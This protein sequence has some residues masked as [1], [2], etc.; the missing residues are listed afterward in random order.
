MKILTAA[1]MKAA[2]RLS[3]ERFGVPSLSLMENAGAAVARFILRELP[4]R[5]RITVFCGMGNNGGDGYVAARHL[6]AAGCQVSVALLG[7]PGQVKGDAK[8]MLD[9]L[10]FAPD[11]MQDEA[12]LAAAGEIFGAAELFVDA[13]VGTGFHPPLGGLAA[14]AGKLLN[15]YPRTPMVSVDL[16]SGWDADSQDLAFPEA[17]RSDAV[18]TFTAPKPAHVFGMLTQR[19][20]LRLPGNLEQGPIVVAAIGSPAEAVESSSGLSWTG[21]SRAIAGHPRPANSNKG[22]F[23]HVLVV[24]GAKGKAGAPS[25]AAL[26]ALRAGAG[27]VTAAVPESALPTVA[28]VAPELMTAPLREG[29]RGEVAAA[30]IDSLDELLTRKSVVAVG[31]GLGQ[32]PETVEYLL[33]LLERAQVP[34]VLDADALNILAAHPDRLD[35]HGKLM[36]LTPHP[37]EMARL[38][39]STIAEVEAHREQTARNFAVRHQVTLVLKGWRTLVAHPDGTLAVNTTGNPGLAKGGSG[40][41][42]TGIVAAMV[43]QYAGRD[44]KGAADAVNAAVYLHGLAADFAVRSGD[45]HTLLA[46]D[47]V[48]HLS[49]AFGFTSQAP[50]GYV[51]LQGLPGDLRAGE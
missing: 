12:A 40:D 39:G 32:E 44:G 1:E 42:L 10:P 21:S 22:M 27:L 33:A 8:I 9:R 2:D 4:G 35:G 3:S 43:A 15:R 34:I 47:T 6:A 26:A 37:G 7:D 17:F 36:V 28:R 29:A 41:I 14:A 18:V 11:A 19:R 50:S 38:A 13:V 5:R 24:G 49:K 16:P 20:A 45:Q 46:T 51:W 48:A 25:M 31:P 30:N 23:G